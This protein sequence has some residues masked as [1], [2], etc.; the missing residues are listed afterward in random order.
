[1]TR[2]SVIEIA[3]SRGYEVIE[4][5]TPVADAME[6]DEIFTS[7]TAVVVCSVGSLTYKGE[8]RTFSSEAGKPGADDSFRAWQNPGHQAG[9]EKIQGECTM[10]HLF[11]ALGFSRTA[12]L[13]SGQ[14]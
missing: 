10:C 14:G 13:E 1:M 6:A 8:K 5:P 12:G 2:D 3:R 9:L 11:R 4:E 7:G